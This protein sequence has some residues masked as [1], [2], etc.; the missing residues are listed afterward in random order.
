MG[1]AIDAYERT[2][3]ESTVGKYPMGPLDLK[4]FHQVAKQN[5]IN[6]FKKK[7]IGEVVEEFTKEFHQKLK[8]KYT[9]IKN[10][11]EKEGYRSCMNFI[12]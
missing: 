8:V 7:A 4:Q 1:D 5:A 11:N 3:K 9:Q 12:Q 6:I 10:D 2:M